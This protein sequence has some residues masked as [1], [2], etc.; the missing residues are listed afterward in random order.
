M[1]VMLAAAR[2]Q[3]EEMAVTV[4][5]AAVSFRCSMSCCPGYLLV[6]VVAVEPAVVLEL[7]FVVEPTMVEHSATVELAT[8][9]EL[10]VGMELVVAVEL[11]VPGAE[12]VVT[13]VKVVNVDVVTVVPV[14]SEQI[15][16]LESRDFAYSTL[17]R[18][19]LRASVRP[20]PES[21]V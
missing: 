19:P 12:L 11:V 18:P 15:P 16:L 7:V 1:N 6:E 8:V 4:L 5:L 14:K 20:P 17:G 21:V 3:A 2:V 10:V 13:V 9:V